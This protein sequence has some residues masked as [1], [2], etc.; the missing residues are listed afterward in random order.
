MDERLES[1]RLVLIPLG[2][3]HRSKLYWL[4]RE[5]EVY[6]YINLKPPSNEGEILEIL[7]VMEEARLSERGCRYALYYDQSFIGTAGYNHINH[8]E[9]RAEIGYELHPEYWGMGLGLE[10]VQ[11]LRHYAF[12]QLNTLRLEAVVSPD[13]RRSQRLL[14]RA[15]FIKEGLLHHYLRSQD[16]RFLDIILY[17]EIN[18]EHLWY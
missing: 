7:S 17:A 5:P 15:G 9:Y 6:R 12:T 3:Q 13:N 8:D 10:A 16:G 14:E 4:W 18:R 1:E 2:E 11:L